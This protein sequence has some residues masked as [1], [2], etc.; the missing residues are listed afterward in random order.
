MKKIEKVYTI[1]KNRLPKKYHIPIKI[2]KNTESLLR[3]MAK[4]CHRSYK[5]IIEYYNKYLDNPKKATYMRTKYF[6]SR[7][8]NKALDIS[9]LGGNP[10]LISKKKFDKIPIQEIAFLLL[11][12][13][14]HNFQHTSDERDADMF[15]IRWVRK[16][17][18]EGL[19]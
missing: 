12:E 2:F 9:A 8:I 4:I 6:K 15:A 10:I 16:L 19:L 18:K 1:L 5:A 3:Y 13:I 17:I 11:H 14:R 7:I